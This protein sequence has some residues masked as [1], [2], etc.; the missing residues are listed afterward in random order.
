MFR[1]SSISSDKIWKENVCKIQSS[2]QAEN[3]IREK[4]VLGCNSGWR[5]WLGLP[6]A[7]DDLGRRLEHGCTAGPCQDSTSV[8]NYDVD[9][10]KTNFHKFSVACS[11][12]GFKY[13]QVEN[14]WLKLMY[15][16]KQTEKECTRYAQGRKCPFNGVEGGGWGWVGCRGIN[17]KSSE[18]AFTLTLPH[19]LFQLLRQDRQYLSFS[20][21]KTSKRIFPFNL[22]QGNIVSSCVF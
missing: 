15:V 12:C 5:G 10:D 16:A 2:H 22:G 3:G 9:T 8:L 6:V 4:K 17:P 14:Y 20:C 11:M 13:A 18:M 7:W 1:S 19:S 21:F